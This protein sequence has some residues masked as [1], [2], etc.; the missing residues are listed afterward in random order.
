ML[1]KAV[2]S[3]TPGLSL[4]NNTSI[5]E[6]LE[7]DLQVITI[8]QLRAVIEQI[9]TGQEAFNNKLKS[10]RTKKI[11]LLVIKWFNRIKIKLKGYFT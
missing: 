8:G 6:I 10:I 4:E 1:L 3:T 5:A 2:V 9:N 11:K 7:P